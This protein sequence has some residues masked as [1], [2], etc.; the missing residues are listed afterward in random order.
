[1]A[2]YQGLKAVERRKRKKELVEKLQQVFCLKDRSQWVEILVKADVPVA[3]VRGLKEVSQDPHFVSRGMIQ[4]IDLKSGKKIR[5]I[6]FPVHLSA[7]PR[8][9]RQPPPELGEHTADVLRE[10]GCTEEEIQ[11]LK[12]MG[13][14]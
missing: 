13:A 11:K 1:L 5:Q 4:E 6:G 9:I 12:Q 7:M 10:V 8:E 2:Q 14:I 3:A